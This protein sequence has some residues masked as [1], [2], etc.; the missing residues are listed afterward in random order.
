MPTP[1]GNT[2]ALFVLTRLKTALSFQVRRGL[3]EAS[4]IGSQLLITMALML[5]WRESGG[6]EVGAGLNELPG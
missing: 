1:S 3:R 6:V 2:Q 4:A 5:A